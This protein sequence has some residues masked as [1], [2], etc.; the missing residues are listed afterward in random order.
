MWMLSAS[1]I[2]RWLNFGTEPTG[3]VSIPAAGKLAPFRFEIK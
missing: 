3:I 2:W 1:S